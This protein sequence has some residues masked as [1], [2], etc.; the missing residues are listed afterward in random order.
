MLIKF[1]LKYLFIIFSFV[2]VFV[3][4]EYSEDSWPQRLLLFQEVILYRFGFVICNSKN[5]GTESFH[6]Q[7]IHLT[8]ESL[9]LRL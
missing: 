3:Y 6:N 8:G 5:N 9:C 7:Y 1:R 2:Y 4:K